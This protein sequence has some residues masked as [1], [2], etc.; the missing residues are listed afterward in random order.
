MYPKYPTVLEYPVTYDCT[1]VAVLFRHRVSNSLVGASTKAIGFHLRRE[2]AGA[3]VYERRERRGAVEVARGGNVFLAARRAT[4]RPLHRAQFPGKRRGRA[5]AV[6]TE[7]MAPVL[8]NTH[9]PHND[10]KRKEK[11]GS[12]RLCY[13]VHDKVKVAAQSVLYW[14][15]VLNLEGL[16][17]TYEK[18]FEKT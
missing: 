3:G 17:I 18:H 1:R 10:K 14:S 13:K 4:A 8:V 9:T 12:N 7:E 6:A 16:V 2:H 15:H 5:F 11:D